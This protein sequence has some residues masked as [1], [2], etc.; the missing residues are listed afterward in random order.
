MSKP[1]TNIATSDKTTITVRGKSLVDELIGRYS[2]T[3]MVYF[4]ICDRF[5]TTAETRIL[6]TCL[7]TLMEHGLTPAAIITRLLLDNVP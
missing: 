5:P 2:Y 4:L 1:T 3:E 6:D 7:V